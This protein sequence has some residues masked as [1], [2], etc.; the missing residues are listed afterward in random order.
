MKSMTGFGRSKLEENS[1]EYIVEIKSVN[2]KYSDISIKMPRNIMCFEEKIKKIISNNISRGKI[3]VFITFNNYSEE[4][5][6]VI[7]NKELAKNYINQL[8][9][10]AN[11][12]GLDDKIRVTEITKMPDVLQLKIEDDESNVIW[13]E[14]EKCVNQAVANFV[15]MREVE[16]E[17]IKQD[18]STRIDNIED[19]VNSIFSNTT[20]LIEEYVVKLR[21]RIKEI[22]QTDVV[23]EARLSQEI[24]IYADKCS[25]EEELTRLRSHIAQFRSLLESKEPVGKKIDFLIQEMNRETNTIASKSVKLEIT[26]LAIDIKTAME[27]IREQIQN[28]E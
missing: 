13:Q 16:G 22:L 8:K 2:H 27:D 15:E 3:D 7:I 6:D 4:G 28:I 25:I 1:R 12:N 26:N 23:D 21:E 19:L 14:L 5:K 24:V 20:G 11:E 9:E 17:R 18:L 10:L